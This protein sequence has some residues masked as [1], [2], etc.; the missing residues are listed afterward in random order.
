MR[1]PNF[2]KGVSPRPSAPAQFGRLRAAPV[3]RPEAPELAAS[4]PPPMPTPPPPGEPALPIGQPAALAEFRPPPTP[5]P[6]I[7]PAFVNDDALAHALKS[8]ELTSQRLAELAKSDALEVGFLVA[9]RILEQEIAHNPRALM[10]L[11]RS[12]LRRLGESRQVTLVLSPAD[13]ERLSARVAAKDPD[14]A[15]LATVKLEIDN[16]LTTGDVRVSSELGQ[17]DGRLQGRLDEL[18]KVIMSNDGAE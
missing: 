6:A 1:Q 4:G 7:R 5:P 9:E 16:T 15:V 8:L 14:A 12:A 11:V 18:R 17:V 3:E 2:L 10:N 13:H